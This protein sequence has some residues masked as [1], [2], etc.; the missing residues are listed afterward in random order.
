VVV[1]VVVVVVFVVVIAFL[2]SMCDVLVDEVGAPY[3]LERGEKS[4]GDKTRLAVFASE[5]PLG[6]LALLDAKES[7]VLLTVALR[8]S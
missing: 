1:V 2:S 7:L 6:L 5:K 3:E 8:A 4:P